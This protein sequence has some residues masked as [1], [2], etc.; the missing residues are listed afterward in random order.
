MSKLFDDAVRLAHT[1]EAVRDKILPYLEKYASQAMPPNDAILSMIAT[2]GP[3]P[4][5][6]LSS[7]QQGQAERLLEEGLVDITL[8][9]RGDGHVYM[10][11]R[12]GRD[13]LAA[14]P[15]KRRQMRWK[16]TWW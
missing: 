1:N 14:P 12:K 6:S 10:I 16:K 13:F 11:T 2:A 3:Y 15:H 4:R 5:K 9:G 7:W 8:G